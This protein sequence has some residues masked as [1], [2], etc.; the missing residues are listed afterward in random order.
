LARKLASEFRRP[1]IPSDP[2][3]RAQ[4]AASQRE[5]LKSVVR[6]KAVSVASAWAVANTKNKGVETKSYLFQMSDGLTVNGVWGRAIG[7]NDDAPVTILLNDKGKKASAAAVADRINRGEQAWALDLLFTGDAWTQPAPAEYAQFLDGIGDRPIGREASQLIEVGHWIQHH[8]GV[9]KLR[10]EASGIRTQT[11]ALV[12]AALEPQMF[13]AVV[14]HEGAQSLDY[15]LEAPVEYREAPDLFCLDLFKEFDLDRLALVAGP[16]R[17]T[18]EK[19]LE[20]PK[21]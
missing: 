15:L 2:Q 6:S 11:A 19:Y 3:A 8:S 10:L 14:V 21:K 16:T 4:W 7:V 17:V 18:V 9:Q 12:A 20:L 13:S 5:K 1:E